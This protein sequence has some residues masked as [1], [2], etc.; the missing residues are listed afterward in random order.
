MISWRNS[1]CLGLWSN[2]VWYIFWRET[3]TKKKTE[4]YNYRNLSRPWQCLL[5]ENKIIEICRGH[6]NA[7]SM[8]N[9]RHLSLRP[10]L[11]IHMS[12]SRPDNS[13]PSLALFDR[14][15]HFGF[16]FFSGTK[17]WNLER[18]QWEQRVCAYRLTSPWRSPLTRS[19][20]TLNA[21][22]QP[23]FTR[24]L[25]EVIE[26]IPTGSEWV[27]SAISWNQMSVTL[28]VRENK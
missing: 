9:D 3:K 2:T 19:V 25:A 23:S 15:E 7:F 18:H 11:D 14:V 20:C 28:D 24:C 21:T 1:R 12:L 26:S 5:Y 13:S 10:Y 22:R 8:D 17:I 6:D 4:K 16:L 27:S